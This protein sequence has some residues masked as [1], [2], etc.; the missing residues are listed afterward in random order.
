MS[1]AFIVRIGSAT[2]SKG[3]T[4]WIVRLTEGTKAV[5]VQSSATRFGTC[6]EARDLIRIMIERGDTWADKA[7]PVRL[8]G[9]RTIRRE[10][11]S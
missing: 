4:C 6:E 7:R 11:A 1:E 8:V 2:A 3:N 10:G 9:K 5:F